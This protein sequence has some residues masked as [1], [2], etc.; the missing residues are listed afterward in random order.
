MRVAISRMGRIALQQALDRMA[1]KLVAYVDSKINAGEGGE[2][3]VPLGS[4][5]AEAERIVEQLPEL[6][7]DVTLTTSGAGDLQTAIDGLTSGQVL[8][9]DTDATY[10]PVVI[11]AATPMTIKAAPGRSPTLSGTACIALANGAANVTISG[12]T[13]DTCASAAPNEQGAGI[14]F[15]TRGV[16]V[17]SIVFHDL[18][19]RNVTAGSGVMLSYHWSIDG[20]NY[21][22]AVTPAEMSH[23]VAFCDCSFFHAGVEGIEGGN[24]GIRGVDELYCARLTIDGDDQNSRGI[25]MVCTINA[26]LVDC[27]CHGFVGAN[28]EC[29]KLDEYG[30]P[31]YEQDYWCTALF[32]RCTAYNGQEGFDIDDKSRG[33]LLHC[34][35]YNCVDEGFSIDGGTPL[36]GVGRIE[37]CVAHDCGIGIRAESGAMGSIHGCRSYDNSTDDYDMSAP[38]V[39]FE[40]TNFS[41]S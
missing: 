23:R 10:D 27:V 26:V 29:F 3:C 7:A 25:T 1:T 24:L 35:A 36:Y 8:V 30:I 41:A 18:A 19:I 9:V 4:W 15:V 32:Y 21:A 34:T 31:G 16:Q 2:G 33:W 28:C 17:D 39:V 38:G 14:S 5:A 20:D 11:P 13:I 6:G 22:R 37:C 40:P 12:L